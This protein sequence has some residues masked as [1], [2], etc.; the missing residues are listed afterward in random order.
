MNPAGHRRKAVALNDRPLEVRVGVRRHFDRVAGATMVRI[1]QGDYYATSNPNEAVTT[2]LGSCIAVCVRDPVIQ[3]GGMNHFV[4]PVPSRNRDDENGVS[5]ALRYG[6][7]AI[8]KLVNVVLGEGGQRER[9]EV[10]VFGG[11]KIIKG[12]GRVGYHNADFVEQYLRRERLPIAAQHL[13]GSFPRKIRYWPSTGL[14]EL[15][16]LKNELAS[17]IYAK[18]AQFQDQKPPTGKIELFS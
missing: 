8:E 9:L 14:V 3:F 12:T 18:E 2:T 15:R 5:L 1:L 17:K 13:R 6:S 7:F 16:E 10:K 4:L 11:A